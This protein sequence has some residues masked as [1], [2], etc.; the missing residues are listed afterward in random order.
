MNS[1][2][3]TICVAGVNDEPSATWN[4]EESLDV[5]DELSLKFLEL[6]AANGQFVDDMDDATFE[7]VV[8]RIH[9]RGFV[10]NAYLP[11]LPQSVPT[12]QGQKDELRLFRAALARSSQAGSPQIRTMGF[13]KGDRA[14]DWFPAAVALFREM[15]HIAG[16]A[17][18]T[19]ILENHPNAEITSVGTAPQI[20]RAL[21]A[22]DSPF[23]RLNL[24]PGNFAIHG[25]NALEAFEI[26][27]FWVA[28]VHV[29]DVGVAHDKSTYC[30]AGDGTCDYPAIFRGLFDDGFSGCITAEPHLN[31][32]KSHHTSGREGFLSAGR[33]KR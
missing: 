30:L 1:Q 17:G 20:R 15:A 3:P 22:V 26:L 28:N 2:Q 24:D 9:E 19:L 25:E 14:S 21:E 32:T 16:E 12:S 29:K 18:Q 23:F 5:L 11:R 7:R 13:K 4:L 6:R 31:H 8:A 10:V 33:R 27:R